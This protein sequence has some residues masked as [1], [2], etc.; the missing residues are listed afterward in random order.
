MLDFGAG[1]PGI[2]LVA[3]MAASAVGV[4]TIA[5]PV[6]TNELTQYYESLTPVAMQEQ[7]LAECVSRKWANRQCSYGSR[8]CLTEC[9]EFLGYDE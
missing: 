2:K 6:K 9:E 3:V 5:E 4:T 7:I 1:F 8:K